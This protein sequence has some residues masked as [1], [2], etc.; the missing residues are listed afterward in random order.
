MNEEEIQIRAKRAAVAVIPNYAGT[1]AAG[2]Y[3]P[4]SV[5]AETIEVAARALR[6]LRKPI[7]PIPALGH[8]LTG[9]GILGNSDDSRCGI[10]QP[11]S[12]SGS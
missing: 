9:G 4:N 10:E 6:D 3:H 7:N 5:V 11:G 1:I 12:S 2:S 8:K